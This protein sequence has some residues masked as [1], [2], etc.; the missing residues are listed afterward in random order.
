MTHH[1]TLDDLLELAPSPDQPVEPGSSEQWKEVERTLGT[2]LPGDYKQMINAY[3]TGEFCDLF[4]LFNP[5]STSAG[6]NLIW[7]AGVPDSL[8][9]DDELGRVYPLGSHL[10]QFQQLMILGN[11][12]RDCPFSTF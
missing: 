2:P 9:N 3:G 1:A 10:E 7:Q 8:E 12:L 4:Y 6:M 11:A 5:F